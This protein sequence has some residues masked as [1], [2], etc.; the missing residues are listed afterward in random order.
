MTERPQS[1]QA[2]GGEEINATVKHQFP[3]F[4]GNR[5]IDNKLKM[6]CQSRLNNIYHTPFAWW[7]TFEIKQW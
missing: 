7:D 4:M 2:V 5:K 6:L 3:K 1:Q